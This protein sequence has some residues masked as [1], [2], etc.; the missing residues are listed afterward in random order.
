MSYLR[1]DLMI[2][3]ADMTICLD[4]LQ[5]AMRLQELHHFN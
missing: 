3:L 2:K 1:L 4:N 5:I